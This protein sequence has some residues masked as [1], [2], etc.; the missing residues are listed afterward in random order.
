MET[1]TVITVVVIAAV[2]VLAFAKVPQLKR[3]V[4]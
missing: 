4:A 1:K 2:V 3:L